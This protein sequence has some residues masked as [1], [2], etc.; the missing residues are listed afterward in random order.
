MY[1]RFVVETLMSGNDC[2]KS[3]ESL[4]IRLPSLGAPLQYGGKVELAPDLLQVRIEIEQFE[5][6]LQPL[7]AHYC[8]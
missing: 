3:R 7:G 1:L 8:Y 5:F 4:A 2:R 6:R